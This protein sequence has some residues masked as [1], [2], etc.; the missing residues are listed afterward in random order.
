MYLEKYKNSMSQDIYLLV[1]TATA[2]SRTIPNAAFSIEEPSG[3]T[4]TVFRARY[5]VSIASIRS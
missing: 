4:L 5:P 3:T 2:V 1:V